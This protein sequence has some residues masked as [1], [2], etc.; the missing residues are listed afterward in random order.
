MSKD[1]LQLQ[2]LLS[3]IAGGFLGTIARYLLS[4]AIQGLLGKSWPFDILTINITGAFLIA[5][6]TTFAEA[7]IL[8]GPKRRLFFNVGFLGA[9][10]TFSSLALGSV[11]LLT[12]QQLWLALLYIVCS[13][14]GGIL[15][16]LLGQY[17]GIIIIARIQQSRATT[18]APALTVSDE[19]EL[20]LNPEGSTTSL[21][22][23][24][25]QF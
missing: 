12:G 15:A 7:A 3:V 23:E 19:R 21:H 18:A 10:T 22:E 2:R 24:E 14:L 6:L 1:V 16:V 17:C 5:L 13:L 25:R 8:I 11:N 4:L 9:Y 20:M